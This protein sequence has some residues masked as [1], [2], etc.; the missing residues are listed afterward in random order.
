M[1]HRLFLAVFLSLSLLG[2][3]HAGVDVGK[4][5]EEV[6]KSQQQTDKQAKGA[7]PP[8]PPAQPAPQP[9]QQP[10]KGPDPV[11]SLIQA[12]MSGKVSLD[13]ELKIG[14]QIAGNLLGASPLVNDAQLQAYVNRV[15]RWVALQSPRPDIPWRFG[16]IESSD[17][18]AFAAPGGY[19]LLTRGLY[20][21]L[22]SEAE[23]A[24]VLAHEIG[25]VMHRHHLKLIQQTSLVAAG[26]EALSGFLGAKVKSESQI[27]QNVIGNGAEILAR[28]LDKEAE[29]EADRDGVVLAA[30]AGYD[31][32]GLPEVLQ[33]I[34]H[35]SKTDSRTALLYKTHP[36]PEDRLN[37]LA[38]AT[39]DRLDNVTG[40]Q[41]SERFYRLR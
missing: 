1:A 14:R 35:G 20:Q 27:I 39:G 30:R 18:N 12:L 7:K 38:D 36:H 28:K 19:I 33:R 24:G 25:H 34:G 15:G 31:A 10:A 29:Y 17:I 21:T 9:A 23:L 37:R 41:L 4:L 6:L 32:F 5:L 16:V 22:N 40:K 8:P 11:Q 3:A 26:G 13:E 2:F